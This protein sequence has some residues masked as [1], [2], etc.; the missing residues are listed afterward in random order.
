MLVKKTEPIEVECVVRGYLAGSGW[1]EYQKTNSIC[2]IK[3]PPGLKESEKL[4]STIF[5]PA[6]K[7][8]SG[9]DMNISFEE[10]IK[11]LGGDT[12]NILKEKSLALYR[13]AADFAL[14]RG[15]IISD[16]KFEFGIYN[17]QVILIDEIFTPDSSRFWPLD[18]YKAG[19][20]Q[21]SF[22]K[23][24]VRDYLETLTWDKNP[25]AP[26]LPEDVISKTTQKYL[27][28]YQRITAKK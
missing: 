1:K 23:Q 7:A 4:T 21:K 15:I 25:P 19:R 26:H 22:D 12:A 9:H 13:K 3:L 24:F 11:K 18:D 16:T 27:E 17:N 5:T 10:A 20:A 14:S 28:A 2:S 6:T 8:K